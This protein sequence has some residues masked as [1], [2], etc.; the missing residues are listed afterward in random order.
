MAL[1][2]K[3]LIPSKQSQEALV[4]MANQFIDNDNSIE[5]LRSIFLTRD[6]EY[7]REQDKTEQTN[8]AKAANAAGDAA[9]MQNPTVPVVAPQVET[10]LAYF[11]EVFLSSYPVFP[12]V[13]GPKLQG[14]ALEIETV[15]GE[16]A[17]HFRWVP[18]L[19]KALR[20]GLKYNLMATEVEWKKDKVFSVE[21]RPAENMT[22]G[23]PVETV[24]EGNKLKRLDPYNLILD[25]RVPPSEVHTKGDY[26][27]Y[28]EL[29][30]RLQLKQL[31][32]DL[33]S[34]LTMNA[35]EAFE[36][37]AGAGGSRSFYF[38]QITSSA[39]AD[40]ATRPGTTNW[41]QWAKLE[42]SKQ[43]NYQD[44]YEVTTLYA[45]VIPKELGI[46]TAKSGTPQI[47]KIILV[48]RQVV[49]YL[50]RK[51]NAHNFL[52]IIVGQIVDDGL[53]YQTKSL[54]E[55]SAPYQQIATSLWTSAMAS[56]RRKVYDR[57]FYD[58][59][60]INKRD[61]DNVD[62]VA[63]IPVKTEAYGKP[64]SEAVYSIPY[65][66]DTVPVVLSM[67]QQVVEMANV[68]FGQNRVSQGQFQKGNKTRFE[69]NEVMTAADARPRMYA[70]LL[71]ASW[72]QPIKHVL[73]SNILQYQPPASLYNRQTQA[74]VQVSP[75]ELRKTIWQF[76]IADGVL[77][78][79]RLI[80][81]ESMNYALQLGMT[82]PL[83]GAEYDILGIF[84]Y[85]M[86]LQ[87]A[88]WIEEFRRT[89]EQKAAMQ[90][91]LTQQNGTTP[92]AA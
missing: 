54:A 25:R 27:G 5:Q 31:M 7:F 57:L 22:L 65:R 70:V 50:E 69:V 9:K 77:P 78:S 58:P 88:N 73:K 52:P 68:S 79:D 20:D 39:F 3:Q 92:P 85:Q 47:Y 67:A 42:T 40:M 1:P 46:D 23:I 90:Q 15:L 17:V 38:P 89:P 74:V 26:A 35:K 84:F 87:G 13:A 55:N 56:Q 44:M 21:N 43:I 11:T 12:V 4:K 49:I 66:D 29:L 61:I 91:Q 28:S 75:E 8:R 48:N 59:S 36:T 45:R 62:P 10:S 72:F 64:I 41:A 76:K 82:Q 37:P 14:A 80:N 81:M 51:T 53:G 60:K 71:E 33:D 83:I 19:A 30:T 2:N 24:F 63:R 18:E 16:S 32:A 6:M 34:S 86:Q